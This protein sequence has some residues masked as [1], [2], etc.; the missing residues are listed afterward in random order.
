MVETVSVDIVAVEPNREEKKMVEPDSVEV[1]MVHPV[2]EEKVEKE[3]PGTKMLDAVM[4]D[5][6][7]MVT[8]W[9]E[10]TRVE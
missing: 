6:V 10:P 9:V 3:R 8:N 1:T 7:N 5:A 2:R 4:L